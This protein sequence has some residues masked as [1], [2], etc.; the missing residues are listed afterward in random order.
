MSLWKKI[1][2]GLVAAVALVIVALAV[3][4]LVPG[5]WKFSLILLGVPALA[6]W[7]FWSWLGE[8]HPSSRRDDSPPPGSRWDERTE[9]WRHPSQ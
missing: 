6:G 3:A 8:S 4:V 9:R 7:L 5:G 1:G 2:I